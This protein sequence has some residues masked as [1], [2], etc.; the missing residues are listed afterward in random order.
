MSDWTTTSIDEAVSLLRRGTAPVYVE[1]SPVRAIGQRCVRSSGFN[2]SA[3]RPHLESVPGAVEPQAG[4]VLLN[5][6]G[7]GTIGRSC[8]FPGNIGKFMVDGHV[9]VLRAR[10]EVAD[11]RIVNEFLRSPEGQRLL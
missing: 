8:V 2:T 7:T 9:T 6:T 1:R 4:D 10:P 11:G 5:S 3:A